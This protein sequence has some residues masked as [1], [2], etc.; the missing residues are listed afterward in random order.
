MT[1]NIMNSLSYKVVP[2]N[3]LFH[4]DTNVKHFL[5]IMNFITTF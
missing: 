4:Y 1:L 3:L 5:H 2:K